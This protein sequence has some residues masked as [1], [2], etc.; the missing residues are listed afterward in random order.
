[1][2]SVN[3]KKIGQRAVIVSVSGKIALTIF[4]FIIGLI[5]GSTA[6]L[7]ESAHTFSD[8]MTSALAFIGF[9]IGLVPPDAEHPYGHGKAE[10]LMGLAIVVFLF[11]VAYEIFSQA[12]IKISTGMV[13]TPPNILAAYMAIIGIIVNYLLTSY[14]MKIGKRINSPAIVAD[15]KHQKVDIY[16]CIAILIGVIGAQLGFPLLDPIVAIIIGIIVLETAYEVLKENINTLMGK[17]P[18]EKLLTRINSSALSVDGVLGVHD[19][20]VNY[21]GPY[22][23]ADLHIELDKDLKLERADEISHKVE[24]RIINDIDCVRMVTVHPDPKK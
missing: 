20:K 2:D 15:A 4:N 16:A 22:A 21:M 12:Y 14:S 18:S 10:P 11:I 5:S 17:V 19:L 9:R 6:L 1:M 8:I 7:V 13:L 23:S 24:K 3:R